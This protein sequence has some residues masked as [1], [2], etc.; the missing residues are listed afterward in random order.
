MPKLTILVLLAALA[1]CATPPEPT[2]AANPYG[3][4][5]GQRQRADKAT[6]ELDRSVGGYK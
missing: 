5:D 6:Q 4:P 3:S 2:P 1:A